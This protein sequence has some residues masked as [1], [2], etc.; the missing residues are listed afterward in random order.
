[1]HPS[2]RSREPGHLLDTPADQDIGNGVIVQPAAGPPTVIPPINP[3]VII[4]LSW[5]SERT[6]ALSIILTA[7]RTDCRGG[8]A[9]ALPGA[10]AGGPTPSVHAG[11]LGR[12]GQG[13]RRDAICR[14]PWWAAPPAIML[15]APAR[16]PMNDDP[17]NPYPSLR[18]LRAG[19]GQP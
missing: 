12:A 14:S 4:M 5:P 6:H 16:R 3:A 8:S 10:V 11:R 15:A 18:A 2:L 13:R 9:A 1:M 7:P 19:Q 17:A